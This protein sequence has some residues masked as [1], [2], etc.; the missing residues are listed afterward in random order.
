MISDVSFPAAGALTG[1]HIIQR[2]AIWVTSQTGKQRLTQQ[3][4]GF[5]PTTWQRGYIGK[6]FLRI[7]G[8]ITTPQGLHKPDKLSAIFQPT[9]DQCSK[10]RLR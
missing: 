5:E 3:A 4:P 8:P 6:F 9:F 7:L 10:N 1:N 2:S